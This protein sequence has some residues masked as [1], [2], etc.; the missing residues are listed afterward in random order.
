VGRRLLAARPCWL[1]RASPAPASACS[2][3]RRPKASHPGAGG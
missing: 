1:A 3:T 2:R